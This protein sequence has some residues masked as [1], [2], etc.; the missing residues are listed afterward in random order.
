MNK[1]EKK[2]IISKSIDLA[3]GKYKDEEVDRLYDMVTNPDSY[4]G[5]SKTMNRSS[6]G[7][8]S[9]GKYSREEKRTY[10]INKENGKISVDFDYEYH[11]DDGDS[12][13]YSSSFSTGRE[14]LSILRDVFD[15]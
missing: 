1:K 10:T 2:Q 11:D 12:G 7:F 3:N 4:I 8:S 9:D 15:I 5:K 14:I 6:S 13:N